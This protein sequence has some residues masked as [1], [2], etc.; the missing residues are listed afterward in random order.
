M[1]KF[2][3]EMPLLKAMG[4]D[5]CRDLQRVGPEIEGMSETELISKTARISS[6]SF[7]G[8]SYQGADEDPVE[9]PECLQA[10]LGVVS[11]ESIG[12]AVT[13]AVQ[14]AKSNAMSANGA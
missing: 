10:G 3:L 9:P 4:F 5:L 12:K 2:L 7:S 1:A 6:T 13:K 11:E 8:L 14:D